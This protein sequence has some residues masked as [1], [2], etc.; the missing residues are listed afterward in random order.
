M[1]VRAKLSL[2]LAAAAGCCLAGEHPG[3][4]R[5]EAVADLERRSRLALEFADSQFREV[6][7]AYAKGDLAAG[8]A[9]LDAICDAVELAVAS[10]Q[11]T[12]KHPRKHP[13]HFKHAEIRTRKLLQQLRDA[14]RKAHLE[15]HGDFD[16]AIRRVEQSNRELLLG[17]MSSRG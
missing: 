7:P 5:I 12:G 17:I 9:A 11:A 4:A 6:E 2:L 1:S 10:L 13:R 16:E 8:R 14:Q 15:D 3:L